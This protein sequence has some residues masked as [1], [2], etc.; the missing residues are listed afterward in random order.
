ML[1]RARRRR[2]TNSWMTARREKTAILASAV[3]GQI[4]VTSCTECSEPRHA[5][6]WSPS[7]G[8]KARRRHWRSFPKKGA[9]VPKKKKTGPEID[10]RTVTKDELKQVDRANGSGKQPV[11]FVHG[12]W[13]LPASWDRWAKLFE[14]AG[15]SA[16]SPGWP[17]DP[18]T[19]EQAK[20]HPEVFAR[21]SIGDI[22]D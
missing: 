22:A 6:C 12:L 1:H 4:D 11:V 7:K 3:S 9:T 15:Y 5:Q 10:E 17:D 13:L 18:D 19:V 20:E 16:L 21:K 2:S 14:A 8:T